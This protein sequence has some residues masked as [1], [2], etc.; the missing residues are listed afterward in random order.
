M[1]KSI[2]NDAT[3]II[4]AASALNITN[5]GVDDDELVTKTRETPANSSRVGSSRIDKT[6]ISNSDYM[7]VT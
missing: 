7:Q 5:R 3:E 4:D 1:R 6:M 2:Y